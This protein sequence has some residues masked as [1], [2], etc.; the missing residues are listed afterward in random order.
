MA[1]KM[2]SD[3]GAKCFILENQ[4]NVD[5]GAMIA[6]QGILQYNAG[7]RMKISEAVVKPYL[8]TD[9]IKVNWK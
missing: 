5:N 8:R 7:D 4:F 2:C 9:D 6:W 1:I 3:R